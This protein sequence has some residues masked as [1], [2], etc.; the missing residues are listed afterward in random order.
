MTS[1]NDLSKKEK[2][3]DTEQQENKIE[4]HDDHQN[5]PE[6]VDETQST[7]NMRKQVAEDI[8]KMEIYSNKKAQIDE[9]EKM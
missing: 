8:E 6:T 7:E 4:I 1:K 5:T 3:T 2:N 9:E